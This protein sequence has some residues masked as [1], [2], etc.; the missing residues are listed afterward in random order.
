MS[1]EVSGLTVR[2][3]SLFLSSVVLF[4][5]ETC[6]LIFSSFN[7]CGVKCGEEPNISL[8]IED[9]EAQGVIND[10]LDTDISLD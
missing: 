1:N 6:S 5:D 9:C 7:F 2:D 4:C 8:K 10:F 3:V